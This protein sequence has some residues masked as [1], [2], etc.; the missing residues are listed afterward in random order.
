LDETED[1][2]DLDLGDILA[3]ISGADAVNTTKVKKQAKAMTKDK[4]AP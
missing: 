2:G 1:K 3:N 4:A